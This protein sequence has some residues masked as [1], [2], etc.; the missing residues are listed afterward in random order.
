MSK[1][2]SIKGAIVSGHVEVLRKCIEEHDF[3]A[4]TLATRFEPGDLDLLLGEIQATDWVDVEIYRRM[5]EFL[6][7][8]AG[9]EN[10]QYLIDAGRR[11]AEN[12]IRAGIHAQFEYLK[13]TQHADKESAQERS[14]AFGRDLRL[15]ITLSASILNFTESDVVADPERPLR[16]I[17]RYTS[18]HPYPEVLCWTT[19]GLCNRMAEEH[20]AGPDLWSWERPHPGLVQLRM[21]RDI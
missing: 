8:Y 18:S 17:I 6:R 7:D 20:G 10:D 12:L 2:P 9:G 1:Q 3:A 15:L 4:T 13:R 19:Q 11:S 5:L 21:C 16:W 14:Q